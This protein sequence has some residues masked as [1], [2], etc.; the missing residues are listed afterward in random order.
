MLIPGGTREL[1]L[2]DGHSTTTK[3]VLLGRK[4]FVK[5]AIRHGLQLVPG[6]CF[7]EKWV[8]DIVLLPAS[9]RAFLHRRFKLAGCALAGRWWSFVGK[10]AQADGTPISLGYV[11]GAPMSIRHDPDCDDQ[12]VQQVHEQYMA[13]VLD[14]FERHKQRFGYSA[15]EQLDF[16]AAED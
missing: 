8:H 16:V 1:M 7:G 3:L 14:L 11:W 4:G 15:E 5:L 13:A 6:F 10:V 9:L 12:Y 2:T